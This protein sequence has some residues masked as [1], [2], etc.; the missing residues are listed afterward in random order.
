MAEMNKANV[1]ASERVSARDM[2][3]TTF[4]GD[5]DLS[6]MTEKDVAK[7]KKK[8]EKDEKAA[9]AALAAHQV[10]DPLCLSQLSMNSRL[11]AHPLGRCICDVP[12]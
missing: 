6:L 10:C 8:A 9:R 11:H 3:Q 5:E 4:E 2:I 1:H 7:M 12:V